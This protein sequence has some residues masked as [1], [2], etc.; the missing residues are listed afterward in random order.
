M[1]NLIVAFFVCCTNSHKSSDK[2][3]LIN[4]RTAMGIKINKQVNQQCAENKA[5]N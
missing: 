1:F 3:Q 4:F 2:N 5:S